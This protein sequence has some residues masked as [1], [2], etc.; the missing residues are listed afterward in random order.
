MIAI[1]CADLQW[2]SE[3]HSERGREVRGQL[4]R[5]GGEPKM[6]LRVKRAFVGKMRIGPSLRGRELK[7]ISRGREHS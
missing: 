3:R 5:R 4:P 7:L 1:V 6:L 2:Q